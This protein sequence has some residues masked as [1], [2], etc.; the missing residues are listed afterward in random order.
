MSS[1]LS[2]TR[3]PR[4]DLLLTIQYRLSIVWNAPIYKRCQ[5]TETALD[6]FLDAR[7]WRDWD[8]KDSSEFGRKA[9]DFF[10]ARLVREGFLGTRHVSVPEQ[11]P[12]YRFTLFSRNRR[13]EDFWRKVL[14]TDEKGQRELPLPET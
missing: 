9:I 3:S 12:I 6:R 8:T 14:H 5:E 11:N 10:C 1:I 2:L 4:I 13:G 7:D